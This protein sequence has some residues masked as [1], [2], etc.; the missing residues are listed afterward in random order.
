MYFKNLLS[1]R[2]K[3]APSQEAKA[4]NVGKKKEYGQRW[5]NFL[6]KKER[7]KAF[8]S[9]I[10]LVFWKITISPDI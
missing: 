8:I 10:S 3:I 4:R 1:Y 6:V 5:D 7:T 9:L 2:I